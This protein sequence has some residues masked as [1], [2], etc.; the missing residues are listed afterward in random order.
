M[1]RIILLLLMGMFLISFV[2]AQ[3]SS[4]GVFK[5]NEQIELIQ[6][7]SNDTS[8]CDACNISS[9]K[10]P[11]SSILISNVAMTER[12]SDFNYTL[13]SSNISVSGTYLVNGFCTTSSQVSVWSYTFDVNYLGKEISSAQGIIYVSLFAILFFVFI[14]I[15]FII[16]KLPRYN[17]QD[18]E[19]RILSISYLKYFRPVLWFTEWMLFIATL[20]ISSNLAFAFL[21]EQLFAKVLFTLF[22]ITFGITPLIVIVWIIWIFVSMFHDKQMQSMLNRGM[23]PEG[24]LP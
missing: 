22:R 4:L 7:C 13:D 18:E 16:G 24:R 6:I 23:F 11:N 3:E 20:Y 1:K 9:V 19:G 5:L 21:N 17:Q 8:L 14:S 15:L 2:S 12:T 10:Y